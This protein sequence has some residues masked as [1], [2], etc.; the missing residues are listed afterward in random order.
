LQFISAIKEGGQRISSQTTDSGREKRWRR[1]KEG[2][3]KDKG[4]LENVHLSLGERGG[5]TNRRT[6]QKRSSLSC[7]GDVIR[8]GDS[9]RKKSM[10][11]GGEN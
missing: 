1:R 9:G 5:S 10:E 11:R 4:E 2:G 3:L 7:G 8:R 6:F